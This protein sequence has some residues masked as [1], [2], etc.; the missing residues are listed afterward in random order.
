MRATCEPVTVFAEPSAM[1]TFAPA[2]A[3]S[4]SDVAV[5][6]LQPPQ[7]SYTLWNTMAGATS[8][9]MERPSSTSV[10]TASG[11]SAASSPKSTHTW[12]AEAAPERR[13]VP[14]CVTCTT[15]TAAASAALWRS[16]AVP[17]PYALPL[18]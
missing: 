9:V 10:T 1:M 4:T 17:S 14:A 6:V 8:H 5:S 18:S 15:V 16:S 12:A 2:A 3:V 13:Y 7:H 11:S